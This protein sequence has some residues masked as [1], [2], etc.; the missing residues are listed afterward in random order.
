MKKIV[1][2]EFAVIAAAVLVVSAYFIAGVLIFAGRQYNAINTQNLE[3]AVKILKNRTPHEVFTDAAVAAQWAS[4]FD[5]SKTASRITLVRKDGRVLFDTDADSAVMENHFDRAEFQAAVRH[6]IGTAVRRSA[7]IGKDSIYAAIA[8]EDSDNQFTGVLRL[9]QTVPGFYFRLLGSALPFLAA[10]FFIII[11]ACV[12]LYYS[13]RRVSHS[14]EVKLNTELEEKTRELKIKSLEA[15]TESGLRDVILNSMFEG[16]IALDK[17][18]NI[19]FANP[20][21]CALFGVEADKNVRGMSLIEFSNSAELEEAAQKVIESDQSCELTIKRY[22]MGA[23]QQFQVYATP[24]RTPPFSVPAPET[25]QREKNGVVI[26]LR[27]I[28]RLVRLEQVRKD[29]VANVS[30]EL[31]TPIQV[32]RGF[33][34]TILDSP[35]ED[36]EKIRHFVGIIKKNAQGMENLTS[37][38]LTLV[39]LENENT[40]RAPLE[41]EALEPLIAEA[42]DA[43]GISSGNKNIDITVSCSKELKARLHSQLFVHALINLLDNAIKYSGGD[44][45]INVN[46][47]KGQKNIFV[48]VKDN[49]IGIPAEHLDRVFE[50]FYRVDRSRSREAGGTGLGLSIVRH[51]ALLHHGTV[52]V[53]SHAGE[54]ST[55]RLCLPCLSANYIDSPALR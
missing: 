47:Y 23:E 35:L 10:G 21:L 6:G 42:V 24:L 43:V 53:E 14:M 7:T 37:D 33:A 1:R 52:E 27:D 28:S 9:S 19:V 48:E 4:C 49:G 5:N 31:R 26:M 32:I 39:R 30:H 51:I 29:F 41:E 38:L 20:R 46:A 15:E 34:E 45:R 40:A 44:S 16:V 11:G 13:F 12:G 36:T 3:E 18:L 22:A 2:N 17:N 55:F 50:R 54:G 8:I 25:G